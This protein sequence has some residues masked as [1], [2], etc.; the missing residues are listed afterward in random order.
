MRVRQLEI[1]KFSE[2]LFSAIV[3]FEGRCVWGMDHGGQ[4]GCE[5]FRSIRVAPHCF[6]IAIYEISYSKINRMLFQDEQQRGNWVVGSK[7]SLEAAYRIGESFLI[8]CHVVGVS[9]E[10]KIGLFN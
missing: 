5:S 4:G 8:R 9:M 10:S 7:R 3:F 1:E 2:C 6:N